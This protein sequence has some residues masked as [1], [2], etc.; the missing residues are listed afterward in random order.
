MGEA[1][2]N[3]TLGFFVEHCC[4]CGIAFGMPSEFRAR[5]LRDGGDFYC[6]GGHRQFYTES[7]NTRLKKQLE[8]ETKRRQWAEEAKERSYKAEIATRGHLTRLKKRV[9]NGVCPCCQ[10]SFINLKR[11]IET[12]HKDWKDDK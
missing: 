11:H 1:L 4:N 2:F 3:H 9:T 10:R 8:Q 7:E 6:P 5:K 12:K